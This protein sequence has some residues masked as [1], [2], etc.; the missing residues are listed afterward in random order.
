M[1]RTIKYNFIRTSRKTVADYLKG[2]NSEELQTIY[3]SSFAHGLQVPDLMKKIQDE[4]QS[5]NM[6]AQPILF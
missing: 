6:V 2:L 3:T 4:L 5:R 1:K